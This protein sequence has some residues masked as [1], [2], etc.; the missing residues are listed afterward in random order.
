MCRSEKV[1]NPTK[2]SCRAFK[3][4]S[5]ES[6]CW[7]PTSVTAK[8]KSSAGALTSPSS[9][10]AST[11][12]INPLSASSAWDC[13]PKS[14]YGESSL[15]ITP[16]ILFMRRAA[17]NDGLRYEIIPLKSFVMRTQAGAVSG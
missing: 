3:S 11:L 10:A 2:G 4:Q 15:F 7:S 6:S 8:V 12:T 9:K 1:C 5:H 14:L 13:P 17:D 16:N